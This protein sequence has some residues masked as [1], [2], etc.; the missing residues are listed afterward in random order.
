MQKAGKK[1]EKKRKETRKEGEKRQVYLYI[2]SSLLRL[3]AIHRQAEKTSK[4]SRPV[5]GNKGRLLCHPRVRPVPAHGYSPPVAGYSPSQPAPAVRCRSPNHHPILPPPARP[6][7]N[8]PGPSPVK[9]VQS[10]TGSRCGKGRGP[11]VYLVQSPRTQPPRRCRR[12]GE[13]RW[14]GNN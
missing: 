8:R 2:P 1:A 10:P 7:N 12:A 9:V 6:P 5:R 11:K 4:I 13:M 14:D 3:L